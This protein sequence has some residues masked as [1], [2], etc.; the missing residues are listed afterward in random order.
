MNLPQFEVYAIEKTG[1]KSACGYLQLDGTKVVLKPKQD[2]SDQRVIRYLYEIQMRGIPHVWGET[3][4]QEEVYL[5]L[6]WLDGEHISEANLPSEKINQAIFDVLALIDKLWMIT[7]MRWFFLDLKPQHIIIDSDGRVSL[8]DFEHVV[9]SKENNISA[10]NFN[11]FGISPIYSSA[12]LTTGQFTQQHHEYALALIWLSLLSQKSIEDLTIRNRKRVLNKLDSQIKLRIESGL[13]GRGIQ[14]K[15]NGSIADL[16]IDVN[17]TNQDDME[18]TSNNIPDTTGFSQ[19]IDLDQQTV[20][21]KIQQ[22]LESDPAAVKNNLQDGFQKN[23][24][25]GGITK[26]T[27]RIVQK[28]M[29][30]TLLKVLSDCICE[31]KEH[32]F[33][34]C[35]DSKN[36][37]LVL[38]T[39]IKFIMLCECHSLP[40]L[41]DLK[42]AY[43]NFNNVVPATSEILQEIYLFSNELQTLNLLTK[44]LASHIVKKY[45]ITDLQISNEYLNLCGFRVNGNYYARQ[46][47]EYKSGEFAINSKLSDKVSGFK[48]RFWR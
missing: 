48:H 33:F 32:R 40:I 14:I 25:Q 41:V 6:S 18:T 27:L 45:S 36:Q 8:I 23:A 17:Q 20:Q 2:F 11:R 13:Q 24:M 5:I 39:D 47:Q 15:S 9:V 1:R 28:H 35:Y 30:D 22:T 37:E 34:E 12:E 38:L 4:Y 31:Y 44:N 16:K 3:K 29:Q 19:I 10:D 42:L 7:G 46:I 21:E 26:N 43:L